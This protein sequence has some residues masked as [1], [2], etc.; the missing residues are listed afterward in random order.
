MLDRLTKES[1]FLDAPKS[2][3][4]GPLVLLLKF[5]GAGLLLVLLLK[6]GTGLLL[7]LL[8]NSGIT[9]VSIGF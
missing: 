8:L 1:S 6:S 9:R 7:V 2:G 4:G 3:T 5:G